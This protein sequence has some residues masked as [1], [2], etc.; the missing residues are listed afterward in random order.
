[1]FSIEG[2]IIQNVGTSFS[3]PRITAIAAGLNFKLAEEFNPTLIKALI[4]HSAKYPEEMKMNI[5]DKLNQAG[6]GLPSNIE[7]ILYNEPNEITLILQD[8][9]E[10]GSFIDILDFPF[11]QSMI[12]ENGY[13]YGEVTVTLVT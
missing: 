12:D 4:I 1:S 9:L 13:F 6:F 5:A 11:P 10:K 8:T 3:T 2:S 7:D